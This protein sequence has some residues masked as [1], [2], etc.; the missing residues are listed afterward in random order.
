MMKA[1]NQATNASGSAP[2]SIELTKASPSCATARRKPC[3]SEC[4][5][6]AFLSPPGRIALIRPELE[7][8][9]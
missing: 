8:S 7:R 2:S 3:S 9:H 1:S 5:S 4:T 6:S